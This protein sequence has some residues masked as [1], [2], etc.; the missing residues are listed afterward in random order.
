[1]ENKQE[2]TKYVLLLEK[3]KKIH[4]EIIEENKTIFDE[5]YDVKNTNS[6]F[7]IIEFKN[8][9]YMITGMHN[10]CYV[11][12]YKKTKRSVHKIQ[13]GEDV[14]EILHVDKLSVLNIVN[15]SDMTIW[16]DD[17]FCYR[18]CYLNGHSIQYIENLNTEM[19]ELAVKRSPHCIQYLDNIPENIIELALSID[20]MCLGYLENRHE[21]YC[22]LAIHQ[23]EY[24]CQYAQNGKIGV[25]IE[26][27]DFLQ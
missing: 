17:S 20:G 5:A 15:I 12:M 14:I 6:G 16:N 21:N 11:R 7:L 19:L 18:A 24:A 25:V 22:K 13:L 9:P 2:L 10:V 23:N 4:N 3:N 1:M 26:V 8:F 27:I